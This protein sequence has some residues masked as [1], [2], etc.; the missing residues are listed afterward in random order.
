MLKQQQKCKVAEMEAEQLQ[1]FLNDSSILDLL[2]SSFHL[3]YEMEI[4]LAAL[5]DDVCKHLD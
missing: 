1:A 3:D 2:Q 5:T 4:A